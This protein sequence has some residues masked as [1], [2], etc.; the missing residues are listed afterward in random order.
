MIE[1]VHERVQSLFDAVSG[2]SPDDWPT[3]LAG[4]TD[5]AS[6]I[7]ET[8]ELL[9]AH[10]AAPGPA[11]AAADCDAR[12]FDDPESWVG[13]ELGPWRLQRL[14]GCGGMGAVFLAERADQLYRRQVALKVLRREYDPRLGLRL[15]EER[16]ILAHLQGTGIARLYDA[17]VTEAGQPYLVMERVKGRP[18]DAFA[19]PLEL[20]DRLRVFARIC[21]IVQTAHAQLVVHCDLKPGNVLVDAAGMPVLLDFGIARLLDA[22]VASAADS[23][24]SPGYA[25]PELLAGRPVGV[26]SDIFSL[27]VI[28]AELLAARPLRRHAG[29]ASAVVQAP[30]AWAG[31][32]CR[33]R[34]KLHGDLDAIVARATQFAPLARYASADALADDVERYLSRRPVRARGKAR[35]HALWLGTRRHWRTVGVLGLALAAGIAFVARL[36]QARSDAEAS[37]AVA[38][39]VSD[40]LVAAF[41]AADPRERGLREEATARDVLDRSAARVDADL[42]AAPEV[43]ARLQVVL[44][45]AYQNLGQPR[46]AERQLQAGADLFRTVGALDSAY[47]AD[48]LLA[49]QLGRE[50]RY[51]DALARL[52][53]VERWLAGERAGAHPLVRLRVLQAGAIA[54]AGLG[55]G[56]VAEARLRAALDGAPVADPVWAREGAAVLRDLGLVHAKQ[57]QLDAS[58]RVLRDALD[59]AARAHGARSFEYQQALGALSGTLYRAGRYD[60]SVRLAQRSLE[61]TA[62]LFGARSSHSADAEARLAGLYLDLGRYADSARHFER[63]LRISAQVDG[64]ASRAYAGKVFAFGLME[65]ARGDVRRAETRYSQALGIYRDSLGEDHAGTLDVEMTL[66]RLL[67]RVDRVAEARPLLQRVAAV[68][69]RTL[70]DGDP[71]LRA[72]ELVEAEWYIRAG[73]FDAADAALSPLIAIRDTLPSWLL[74]RLQ[75]Q[76]ALLAQRREQWASAIPAW[77]D[78]VTTFARLYGADSTATAKW[79]IPFAEVLFEGGLTAEAREEAHRARPQLAGLSPDADFLQRLAALEQRLDA[80]PGT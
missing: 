24:A 15:A 33:W 28:L 78:V 42:S 71:Q 1:G 2:Q 45:R 55:Q 60:E 32:G 77:R 19:Q 48:A 37:A 12:S 63:S 30:S 58:E 14:I 44:G 73:Q 8:L 17:G 7:A 51:E 52:A 76:S 57:G 11:R 23:Y 41:E 47:D 67:M 61:L 18:L 36:E 5:D 20:E 74:L 4:L 75:M 50:G 39:Q 70:P 64:E 6:E 26:A 35:L 62:I 53:P 49:L 46:I 56:D 38:S 68:M 21:R 43:Q 59:R 65:E 9:R 22:G 69:R 34:R 16:Q 27:G 72:L 13:R 29:E 66:A 80:D 10:T 31:P 79:R 25:S 40:F 3:A 54:H